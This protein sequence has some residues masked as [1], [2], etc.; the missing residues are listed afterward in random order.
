MKN[1]T[2]FER[3]QEFA[4]LKPTKKSTSKGTKQQLDENIG[5]IVG[6]GAINNPLEREK[7]D[8]ELAFEH[9]VGNH[10]AE[11]ARTDAE[12]EGYLD[13]MKDEEEDLK[14][15]SKGTDEDYL[16]SLINKLD[17][18]NSEIKEMLEDLDL[19]DEPE[20]SGLYQAVYNIETEVTDTQSKLGYI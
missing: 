20:Y 11:D 5:G 18:I 3:M 4:G 17:G 1:K 2:E 6:I 9:Y 13:G 15:D 19:S 12:E 16:R 8:Y 14:E 10:L 7:P